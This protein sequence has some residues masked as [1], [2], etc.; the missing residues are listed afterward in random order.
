[1][2]F[3]DIDFETFFWFLNSRPVYLLA[4][5]IG[6]HG[7]YWSKF[8][9]LR[10]EYIAKISFLY[11]ESY[12]LNI[13]TIAIVIITI[14]IVIPILA[15]R[16]STQIIENAQASARQIKHE[17]ESYEE[18]IKKEIEYKI[19]K[20]SER[21]VELEKSYHLKNLQKNEE[22]DHIRNNLD[23]LKKRTKYLKSNYICK[24][25]KKNLEESGNGPK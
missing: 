17:A 18:N 15:N 12:W 7:F 16:K 19:D 4:G 24:T 20:I 3:D 9:T 2:S 1:M 6:T 23:Q 21:E 11:I 8:Q 14:A 10:G 5:I 13:L 25:C 22:L